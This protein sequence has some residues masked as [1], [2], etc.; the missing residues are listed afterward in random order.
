MISIAQMFVIEIPK[1]RWLSYSLL[2]DKR[3]ISVDLMQVCY[4]ETQTEDGS[5][6]CV[7][8]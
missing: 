4:K 1:L 3:G 8:E 2:F 5:G 7:C 6:M